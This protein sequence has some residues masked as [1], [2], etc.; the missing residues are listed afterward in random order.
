MVLLH[1]HLKRTHSISGGCRRSHDTS[2][3]AGA[4]R[5]ALTVEAISHGAEPRFSGIANQS[6]VICG[7]L[8]LLSIRFRNGP[9]QLVVVEGEGLRRGRGVVR[10]RSG[11]GWRA[12]LPCDE[13]RH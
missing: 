12:V 1:P 2:T 11:G 5:L 4:Y 3:C 7:P 13:W 6:D 10:S 8:R 9:L